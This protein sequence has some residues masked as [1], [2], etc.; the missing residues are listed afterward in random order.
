VSV[1]RISGIVRQL[2][3]AGRLAAAAEKL[4]P[5]A[6][7]AAAEEAMLA[8]SAR[9]GKRAR[10]TNRVSPGLHVHA[11]EGVVI[12]VLSNLVVNATQAISETRSDG[13]IVIDAVRDGARLKVIVEDNGSGIDPQTLRRVFEPFFTTKPAGMGTGLGLALSRGLVSGLGGELSL[14]SKPGVGT[15]AILELPAADPPV[16]VPAGATV[17]QLRTRPRILVVD[18]EPAVRSSLRRLLEP[19]YAVELAGDVEDGL[20][21]LDAQ[22]FDIVLCDV[23]MPDGGGER[24]YRSL[25]ASAPDVASRVVFLTGGAADESSRDFLSGQHRPVLYKPL[26]VEQLVRVTADL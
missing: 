4:H 8:A 14:E 5:V 10:A 7:R 18:D 23:G 3:D 17:T 16:V 11:Q 20:R 12:Q 13:R 1:R 19:R 6:V 2:L 9:Y 22:R 24:L 26:D 15:R 21:R 25:E